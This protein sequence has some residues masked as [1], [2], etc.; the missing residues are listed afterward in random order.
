[1]LLNSAPNFLSLDISVQSTGWFAWYDKKCYYGTYALT[2]TDSYNR[3]KEFGVFVKTLIAQYQP[4]IIYQEDVISGCNFETTRALTELNCVAD[5]L[6]IYEK[7]PEIPLVRV[8]NVTWKR[9][10]RSISQSEV[11]IKGCGDKEEVKFTLNSLG[12]NA[13][14]KQDIYD[15]LGI[16][17][18]Q[19]AAKAFDIKENVHI[20]NTPVKK[21]KEDITKGYEIKQYLSEADLLNAANM[22]QSRAKRVRPVI[23]ITYDPKFR[24]L[25]DCFTAVVRENGDD[26]IFAITYPINKINNIAL[27]YGFDL[28]SDTI[29]MLAKKR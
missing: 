3:R 19:I 11:G 8:N 27:T 5:D 1:M 21:L 16:G 20:N 23:K 25:K 15:A 9:I 29:Y 24:S 14:V 7:I 6:M 22:T 18:S 12:F 10:L 28:S 26:G 13:D 4:T 2:A 17:L